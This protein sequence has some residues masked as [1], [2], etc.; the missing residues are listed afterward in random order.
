LTKQPVN[1]MTSRQVGGATL[2]GH[3]I[4]SLRWFSTRFFSRQDSN[5][6]PS[7]GTSRFK[8]NLARMSKAFGWK[9]SGRNRICRLLNCK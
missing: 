8:T 5:S 2:L 6:I 1:R 3:F 7:P 4:I 9:S